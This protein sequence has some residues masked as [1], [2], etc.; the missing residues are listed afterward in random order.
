[1]VQTPA[2]SRIGDS[3]FINEK[4]YN[5][6]TKWQDM[7]LILPEGETKVVEFQAYRSLT[8]SSIENTKKLIQRIF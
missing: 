1:M 7:G 5:E 2:K 3:I 6:I 4:I 8:A